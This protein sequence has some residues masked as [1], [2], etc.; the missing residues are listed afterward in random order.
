MLGAGTL[1]AAGARAQDVDPLAANDPNVIT[2]FQLKF[3]VTA[4]EILTDNAAGTAN[5]GAI[6][7]N[8]NG[9][10]TTSAQSKRGD[11][12]TQVTPSISV[13]DV[14]RT[15]QAGLV[16]T[17]SYQKYLDN[18]NL[19]RFDNTLFTSGHTAVWDDRLK[20]D[21]TSSISRQIINQ[22]GAIT[23]SGLSNNV[24]QTTV[25]TYTVTPT[26]QQRFGDFAVGQLQYLF[27][28]TSSDALAPTTQNQGSASLT[29]GTDFNNIQWI[30]TISDSESNQGN[31]PN[32]NQTVNNVTNPNQTGSLSDRVGQLQLNYALNRAVTLLSSAGYE[33]IHS[34]DSITD[35]TGPIGSVGVGLTGS[36][37]NLQVNYNW[38][39][40]GHFISTQGTYN[41]TEQLQAQLQYGE[42]VTTQ[43]NQLIGAT[44]LGGFSPTGTTINTRTGQIFDAA[45]NLIGGVNSGAG[46]VAIR[47]K[48]GQFIVT[49][50]Y[51]RNTW[52]ATLIQDK[53]STDTTNFNQ[54]TVSLTGTYARDLTP[55]TR[56]NVNLGYLRIAQ[57]APT[58]S[59]DNTYNASTGLS[60][61][62]GD[63][64]TASATYAFLYRQ[65]SIPGQ[66]LN[67]N[68]LTIGLQKNF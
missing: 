40:G 48:T 36:K 8:A 42:S 39:Y 67:E 35:T 47:D 28:Y 7:T 9:T 63:D 43:Q 5:G 24:N 49:G 17:P 68:S 2:G 4:N 6:T 20:L 27:G 37:L 3:G 56:L 34:T 33:Q 53:Q 22:R 50:N 62:L 57:T 58:S 30:A 54:N 16:Y 32:A 46:N 64:F 13:F 10:T 19:D 15:H 31:Q 52:S 44:A 41:I 29:S 61:S 45:G 60:W 55:D 65:S 11:L 38:R 25:Q 26:Y 66:S 21:T 12:V 18:S 23:G 14:T 51:D 1:G 59:T